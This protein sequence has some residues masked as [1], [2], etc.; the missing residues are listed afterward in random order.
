R[1]LIG[2]PVT[3]TGSFDVSRTH[4]IWMP[5]T[6]CARP[7]FHAE[8]VVAEPLGHEQQ[9]THR[10]RFAAS[11]VFSPD[12]TE[13]VGRTQVAAH[14]LHRGARRC[15]C[16]RDLRSLPTGPASQRISSR[17]LF[18]KTARMATPAGTRRPYQHH[19]C[20]SVVVLSLSSCIPVGLAE[21]QLCSAGR[22]SRRE[23]ISHGMAGGMRTCFSGSRGKMDR[24]PNFARSEPPRL[25]A[26]SSVEP[27]SPLAVAS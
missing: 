11:L 22:A 12:G 1:A 6:S 18:R 25:G 20:P 26:L 14:R 10:C 5:G 3:L 24:L 27:I 2:A 7:R 15:V 23:S 21:R 16:R 13:T 19:V 9:R 4:S 8:L 17:I